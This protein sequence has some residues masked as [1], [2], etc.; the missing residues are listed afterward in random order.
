M[1]G[2]AAPSAPSIEGSYVPSRQLPYPT[3]K[4]A[5]T[6]KEFMIFTFSV[7]SSQGSGTGLCHSCP[8]TQLLASCEKYFTPYVKLR[9]KSL[10]LRIA[11]MSANSSNRGAMRVSYTPLFTS[12]GSLSATTYDLYRASTVDN[13]IVPFSAQE[14][15]VFEIPFVH[16]ETLYDVRGLY[17]FTGSSIIPSGLYIGVDQDLANTTGSACTVQFQVHAQLIEPEWYQPVVNGASP[18]APLVATITVNT[19]TYTPALVGAYSGPEKEAVEKSKTGLI[20]GIASTVVKAS[21]IL[22]PIDPTGVMSLTSNVARAVGSVAEM[23]GLD[24]PNSLQFADYTQLRIGDHL[25][26]TSGLD[27]ST[28]FNVVPNAT[29]TTDVAMMGEYCDPLNIQFQASKYSILQTG[30]V[31]STATFGSL[32]GSWRIN[33]TLKCQGGGK[34][35]APNCS[36]FT[37]MFG[38]WRGDIKFKLTIMNDLFFNANLFLVVFP[39]NSDPLPTSVTIGELNQL[40]Y[41]NFPAAG[42]S[43]IE[44]TLPW[45]ALNEWDPTSKIVPHN[46]M[47]FGLGVLDAGR[48]SGVATNFQWTLEVAASDEPGRFEVAVPIGWNPAVTLGAFHEGAKVPLSGIGSTAM[49]PVTSYKDLFRRYVY[50]GNVLVLPDATRMYPVLKNTPIDTILSAFMAYRGSVRSTFYLQ[51][52][53]VAEML[54]IPTNFVSSELTFSNGSTLPGTL[55]RHEDYNP[56]VAFEIPYSTPFKFTAYRD[57]ISYTPYGVMEI[58]VSPLIDGSVLKQYVALGD[59]FIVGCRTFIPLLY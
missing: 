28:V 44:F 22:A 11:P 54:H 21:S 5:A 17:T 53:T 30:T 35:Y 23:F 46:A 25:I 57:Y 39:D 56:E 2:H 8:L 14:D 47:A 41:T 29:D 13:F 20:S 3:N 42:G 31:A 51:P 33:P 15:F 49:V 58:H 36:Y 6:Q 18:R 59:D 12:N 24:K 10:Q 43:V 19:P 48:R 50:S 55:I 9:Y 27:P 45:H 37:S 26:T 52:G 40:R 34:I 16:N 38:F 7:S 1:V 4:L 32:F